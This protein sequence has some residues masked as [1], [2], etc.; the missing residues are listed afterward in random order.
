MKARVSPITPSPRLSFPK[1]VSQA[2]SITSG[3]PDIYFAWSVSGL[4]GLSD[5]ELVAASAGD[6]FTPDIAYANGAF[7]IVWSDATTGRVRYRKATITNSAGMRGTDARPTMHCWPNPATDV[8]HVEGGP[9]SQLRITDTAGRERMQLPANTTTVDVSAL[10][11]GIYF[12]QGTT[13]NAEK[14]MVMRVM[15]VL[16]P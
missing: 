13:P 10:A 9:F 14:D 6:Q 7:H 4:A 11:T 5:P 2:E 12:L 15:V 8:L 1:P 16:R 3:E